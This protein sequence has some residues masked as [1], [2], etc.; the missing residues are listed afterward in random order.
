MKICLVNKFHYIKGG[1]ETYYFGLGE[2]LK[3]RGHDV[4]YFSM[5]D[6]KNVPCNQENFFVDN[7]DFNG[8]MSLAKLAK[9]SLKMLY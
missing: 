8:K 9:T 1:S 6:E 2:L 3:K 7:V 4:I 5:K